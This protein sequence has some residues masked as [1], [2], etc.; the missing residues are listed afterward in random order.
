MNDKALLS[1]HRASLILLL[2]SCILTFGCSS[3]PYPLAP[4]RAH[5][6][7]DGEDVE[8]ATVTLLPDDA[9]E[10]YAAFGMTDA[11]GRC[12]LTTQGS[13]GAVIGTHRVLV[14]KL[15]PVNV[16]PDPTPEARLE[17]LHG[18]HLVPEHYSSRED[19]PLTAVVVENGEQNALEFDLEE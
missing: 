17:F 2:T 15:K 12:A 18:R 5:V 10:T 19:S 14:S 9:P 6:T 13:D 1:N 16:P 11:S 8:G 7:L 4:A 3:N